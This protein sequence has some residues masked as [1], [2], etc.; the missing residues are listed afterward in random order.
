[1][2]RLRQLHFQAT[3]LADAVHKSISRSCRSDL[4]MIRSLTISAAAIGTLLLPAGHA[5]ANDMLRFSPYGT[6]AERC[7]ILAPVSTFRDIDLRV[8]GTDTTTF[9]VDCNLPVAIGISAENGAFRPEQTPEHVADYTSSVAYKA[10][11]TLPMESGAWVSD[12]A[13]GSSLRGAGRTFIPTGVQAVTPPFQ[14]T[15]SFRMAWDAPSSP[16]VAAT[17]RE[18]VIISVIGRDI[19]LGM[20]F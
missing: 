18:T 11:F 12:D 15:L 16:L 7:T 14:S 19:D 8:A 9:D 5:T 3:N 10:A 6:V 17:Y 2:T 13:S 20:S 4:P 1:M